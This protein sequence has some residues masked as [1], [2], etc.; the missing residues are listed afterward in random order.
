M[1]SRLQSRACD[2]PHLLPVAVSVSLEAHDVYP[3]HP[4]HHKLSLP[5][6]LL[7]TPFQALLNIYPP[8]VLALR[9]SPL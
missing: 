1:L 2:L 7:L 5:A 6:H 3:L 8:T 4:A 9:V